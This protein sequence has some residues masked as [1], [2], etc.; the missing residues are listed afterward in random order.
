[1]SSQVLE[2]HRIDVA[3]R[4]IK[5]QWLDSFQQHL[6][7]H[8]NKRPVQTGQNTQDFK[9]RSLLA[10]QQVIPFFFWSFMAH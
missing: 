6:S 5:K 1:M 7:D 4:E 2:K 10:I 8:L 3:E 9:L